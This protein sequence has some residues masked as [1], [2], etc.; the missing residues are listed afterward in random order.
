MVHVSYSK[1]H[2]CSASVAFVYAIYAYSSS[3]VGCM[4][5]MMIGE[6]KMT[7]MSHGCCHAEEVAAT[8]EIYYVH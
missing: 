2:A 7:K 5:V 4:Q 1:V 3:S 6:A 8:I